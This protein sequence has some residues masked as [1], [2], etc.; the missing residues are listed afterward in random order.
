MSQPWHKQKTDTDKSLEVFRAYL[1]MQERSLPKLAKELGKN[2]RTL[3]SWSSKYNWVERAAAYDA[4][5]HEKL[6]NN[7]IGEVEKMNERHI[8][9]ALALQHLAL[10]RVKEYEKD[11]GKIKDL[12]PNEMLR[13]FE[14]GAKLE[15]IAR[16]ATT[17][18]VDVVAAVNHSVVDEEILKNPDARELLKQLHRL[19][20]SSGAMESTS[21]D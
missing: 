1:V 4:H 12:T 10:K 2:Q 18:N 20:R 9:E 8:R 21:K 6:V 19:S 5:L 3:E 7:N 17:E 11:P 16:G 15:R 14:V 13:M